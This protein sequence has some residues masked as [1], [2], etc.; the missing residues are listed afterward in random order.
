MSRLEHPDRLECDRIVGAESELFDKGPVLRRCCKA[1][2]QPC[3]GRQGN[4]TPR[5]VARRQ[6]TSAQAPFANAPRPGAWSCRN[7]A[8]RGR[9][10]LPA[11]RSSRRPSRPARPALQF[12]RRTPSSPGR[13]SVRPLV[14]DGGH[15]SR[16]RG[17]LGSPMPA[18]AQPARRCGGRSAVR[19]RA[20]PDRGRAVG[21][22]R[23]AANCSSRPITASL[24][25][26][27]R[28]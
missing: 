15:P 9:L 23:D 1:P 22:C 12:Y 3:C 10:Q 24:A 13:W 27:F 21:M 20:R 4:G 17:I 18:R 6:R 19:A 5:L 16:R 26:F 14:C 11:P 25:I 2:Q 7:R 28:S 8:R